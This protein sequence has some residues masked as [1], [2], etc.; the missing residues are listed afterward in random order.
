[1]ATPALEPSKVYVIG[2]NKAPAYK[3]MG[4]NFVCVYV[5]YAREISPLQMIKH[6]VDEIIRLA[7]KN[8]TAWYYVTRIGSDIRGYSD[9]DIAPM[10]YDAPINC[11]LPE[12]W[13]GIV[14]EIEGRTWWHC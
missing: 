4:V 9:D 7:K 10:F 12:K 1:M 6:D 5:K 8:P 2:N 11:K 3:S 14:P 13:K